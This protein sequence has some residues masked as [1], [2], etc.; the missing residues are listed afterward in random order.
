M[1]KIRLE[2]WKSNISI[3]VRA[4]PSKK[5][6]ADKKQNKATTTKEPGV[7][8]GEQTVKKQQLESNKMAGMEGKEQEIQ[9]PLLLEFLILEKKLS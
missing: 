8:G 2:N 1:E 6:W 5:S 7:G 4:Q 9:M 3:K